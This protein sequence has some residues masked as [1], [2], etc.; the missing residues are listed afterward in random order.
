MIGWVPDFDIFSANSNAPHRFDV[1]QIPNDF[2]LLI[3]EYSWRS[4]ILTA[5]SQIEYCV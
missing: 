2:I 5:P 1:S 4:S 3:F